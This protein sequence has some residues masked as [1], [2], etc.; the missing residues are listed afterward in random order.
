MRIGLYSA[1][2][3]GNVVATRAF[4]AARGYSERADAIRQCRQD[5]LHSDDG[6]LKS[7]AQSPDFFTMSGCRDLAFHVQEHL[8][9]IPAI[10]SFLAESG[11]AFIGFDTPARRQYAKLYPDDTAMV[12]LDHWHEF[13]T[14]NPS[15]FAGMYQFWLQKPVRSVS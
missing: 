4:I 14:A 2:A 6:P 9:D 15:T 1:V 12:D 7:I 11:L 3:R 10:K 8:T 13:E 5:I